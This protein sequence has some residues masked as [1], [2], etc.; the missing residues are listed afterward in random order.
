MPRAPP[1]QAPSLPLAKGAGGDRGIVTRP[2]SPYGGA[3]LQAIALRDRSGFV[4][5][6]SIMSLGPRAA[7]L[8]LTALGTIVL[9]RGPM[10]RGR[11]VLARA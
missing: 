9:A 7:T 2:A 11:Q 8:V 1:T 4:R 5:E 6:G 3:V 10:R